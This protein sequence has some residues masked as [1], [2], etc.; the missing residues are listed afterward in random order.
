MNAFLL[1]RSY[2][3]ISAPKQKALVSVGR[4]QGLPQFVQQKKRATSL[5][6]NSPLYDA[7]FANR[8]ILARIHSLGNHFWVALRNQV[9]DNGWE[10]KDKDTVLVLHRPRV[11]ITINRNHFLNHHMLPDKWI[12]RKFQMEQKEQFL[13]IQKELYTK[14]CSNWQWSPKGSTTV[15]HDSKLFWSCL[16]KPTFPL[17]LPMAHASS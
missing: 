1:S 17:S 15:F 5:P 6:S 10:N 13:T 9:Q 12:V 7:S 3:H 4:V 16:S 14:L 2:R 11:V 8:I